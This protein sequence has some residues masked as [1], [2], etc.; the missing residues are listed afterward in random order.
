M[1]E[2]AMKQNRSNK[3]NRSSVLI[4]HLFN[5]FLTFFSST[6]MYWTCLKSHVLNLNIKK[7]ID[8]SFNQFGGIQYNFLTSLSA[9]HGSVV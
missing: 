2:Q 5:G 9:I 4:F 8:I 6:F 1:F 3:C 7:V